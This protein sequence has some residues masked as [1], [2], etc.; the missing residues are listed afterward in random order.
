MNPRPVAL[1]A[2]LLAFLST[3]PPAPAVTDPAPGSKDSRIRATPYDP[4]QVVRLTSTGLSPL[5]IIFEDGERPVTIA[6]ALVFTDPKEAKDWLAR[7]SGNVLILQPLRAME[8]SVLFVRTTAADGKERHYSFE[9]RTREG[10]VADTADPDAYMTVRLTYPPAPSPE[11]IAAARARREAAQVAADER[12]VRVRFA[13]TGDMGPRNYNY[14]KRDPDG[15]PLL[16]PLSVFD[17]GTRT[18]LLFAPHAVLPEIY[19]INQDGKEA[20]AT[21]V[22]DTTPAGLRVMVPSVQ[23][24]MRLR[25]G[26]KVCALRDNAFDPIGTEPGG[27]NGTVSQDVVRRVRT[28]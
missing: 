20:V 21:T 9:L 1:A 16:A 28:P 5:Q 17:D 26:G 10:N 8:P 12:A 27:G 11:A 3:S 7:P 19:V 4:G 23:R 18:T 25:R 14:D 15:C 22:D 6:G 13:R 24:E 2:S